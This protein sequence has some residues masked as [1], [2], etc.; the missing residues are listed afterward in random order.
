VLILLPPSEGKADAGM[1]APL[2]PTSL[3]LPELRPARTRVLR[4]L[5]KLCGV[6]SKAGRQ[7]ALDTL[8]LSEG[9]LPE[10]ARNAELASAGTLP[11]GQLYTGV[12]YDALDLASLA[13]PA[14]TAAAESI[15]ISS[16]LWGAV[17]LDDRIPPYRCSI[18]VTMPVLG[19]LTA[20]W[21]KA[22]EPV[23]TR[24][25]GDGLVLD[26]RSGAYAATWMPRGEVAERTAQ[27]RVLHERSGKRTVVSH[28]NKATKGRI[29]RDLLVA[30]A[31][32]G[33]PSELAIALGDLKYTV[34]QS[35]SAP[36]R[37][38]QLDVIVREL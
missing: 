34:E 7:R 21:K 17:R 28:F 9:Q 1:G 15:L 16:G 13:P 33:S 4:A 11:A 31:R 37:P 25:V 19:G 29:V 18:G 12:L 22:L 5:G 3:S 26:L 36:G 10:L 6:K 2:D 24:T 20:Y 23:L 14:A 8:G 35:A 30:G 32:P 27:V 38:R